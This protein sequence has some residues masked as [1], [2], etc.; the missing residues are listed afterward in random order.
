VNATVKEL[1]L[2][3]DSAVVFRNSQGLEAQ[4]T[5]MRLNRNAVVFEVYNPYSIV[6]LSE[7]LSDLR[8]RRG[9]RAIYTGRAV[10]TNLVSTGLLLIVSAS[11]VDPWSDLIDL[12]PGPLLRDE[13]Q[14]FVED[15]SL[16]NQ[17]LRPAY[18]V[19]VSNIRNFLEE[20]SRW[21]EH[22]ETVAGI[23]E[24]GTSP[25]LVEEFVIDVEAMVS[26]TL[27]ELF[28]TFED[29]ANQVS[30]DERSIHKAFARREI[31]P[32]MMCSPFMHRAYT[33]PLGYAGDFEMVNMILR[34]RWE[35]NNTYAKIVN[36]IPLR[37]DTAQAH[38]NRIDKLAEGITAEARRVNDQGRT[39]RVLNVG[40]GPAAEVQ[41]FIENSWLSDR[42]EFDLVDFNQ[43]TLECAESQLSVA[44]RQ[45]RRRTVVRYQ[46]QSVHQLL[47]QAS[48]R[49]LDAK[50]GYDLVYC[51]G[52][53]D[54]LNDRICGRLLRLFH[55]WTMPGGLVVVTNVHP[56]QSARG[57]MEHLQEWNLILRDEKQML[58]LAPGL[59]RQTISTEATGANVFL[60][61]R[62][63]DGTSSF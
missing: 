5:L 3:T 47:K 43:A 61:I 18:Q 4:G 42:T 40:C 45:Y 2:M 12:S 7:V 1:Q 9:D 29:E 32:L 25:D 15:W 53:F 19:C 24:P 8:I 10:V 31:H 34:N 16:G 41:A 21:L 54:Y 20:F 48:G 52:L 6:Q 23:S 46:H 63:T 57:F 38:R 30:E 22:G 44:I 60:D 28:S 49:T 27:D 55:A 33:K 36:S 11:L 39:F 56:R 51:A 62:R 13:V 59:G 50:P 37:T 35:G 26:P 17:R 14:G 58:A